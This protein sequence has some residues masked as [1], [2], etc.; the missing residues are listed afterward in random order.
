MLF[1][2]CLA[3]AMI[4]LYTR[5]RTPSCCRGCSNVRIK[6][7]AERDPHRIHFLG[8][9]NIGT[10]FIG[11]LASNIMGRVVAKG[12]QIFMISL[13]GWTMVESIAHGLKVKGDITYTLGCIP[14]ASDRVAFLDT[15]MTMHEYLIWSSSYT[16]E[17]HLRSPIVRLTLCLKTSV[18]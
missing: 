11:V 17:L 4:V 8:G 13:P 12:K 16:M 15:V 2:S 3:K 14:S 1:V 10:P 9:V 18:S 6:V 5:I 7:R